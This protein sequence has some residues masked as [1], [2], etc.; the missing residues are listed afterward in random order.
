MRQGIALTGAVSQHG[1]MLPVGD[2]TR[3]IEGFYQVCK[4]QGFTGTQGVLIPSR[5]VKDLMLGREVLDAVRKRQFHVY[6]VDDVDQAMEILTG[7]PAGRRLR[8]GSF[9]PGSL[10]D[11]I[12][13]RLRRLNEL[14]REMAHEEE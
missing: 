5:N 6:A 14:Y 12:D 9:E 10:N 7:M 1:E 3:K 2:V 4:L 13:R 11:R 8:D